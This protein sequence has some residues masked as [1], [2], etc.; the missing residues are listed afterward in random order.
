[1][2]ENSIQNLKHTKNEIPEDLKDKIYDAEAKFGRL[3]NHPMI[4]MPAML[5]VVV[6]GDS[7]GCGAPP[8]TF[9]NIFTKVGKERSK[10]ELQLSTAGRKL[11][12][13]YS[14]RRKSLKRQRAG[15]LAIYRLTWQRPGSNTGVGS[16]MRMILFPSATSQEQWTSY[17]ISPRNR[18]SCH[19]S[20]PE[21]LKVHFVP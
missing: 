9:P 19:P 18:R 8:Q 6:G 21:Q 10:Q 12:R 14:P 7:R 17:T 11:L 13:E 4:A 3:P 16:G 20:E 2:L 15:G 5:K 1:M